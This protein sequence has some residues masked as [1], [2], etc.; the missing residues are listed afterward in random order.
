MGKCW[1]QREESELSW[2]LLDGTLLSKI[3]TEFKR[4]EGADRL[5]L[6]TE[7]NRSFLNNQAGLLLWK[8]Q[9]VWMEMSVRESVC[10]LCEFVHICYVKFFPSVSTILFS[11]VNRSLL[12]QREER[13][14][15]FPVLCLWLFGF[16]P[17]LKRAFISNFVQLRNKR[18]HHLSKCPFFFLDSF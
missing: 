7:Q 8:K 11:W 3:W 4:A 9:L 17:F 10:D 5:F 13:K 2:E 15:T 1:G 6:T 14:K 16:C 18:Y 12:L